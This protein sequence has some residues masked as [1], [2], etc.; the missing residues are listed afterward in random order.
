M[1]LHSFH[2]PNG[3]QLT[4]RS[5][6]LSQDEMTSRLDRIKEVIAK[7]KV[8]A[9]DACL[10]ANGGEIWLVPTFKDVGDWSP[11]AKRQIELE[12]RWDT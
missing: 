5:S 11:I 7:A 4:P 1:L 3:I 2:R 6:H 12:W 8:D 10:S 9:G